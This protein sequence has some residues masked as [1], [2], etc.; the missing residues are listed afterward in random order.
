MPKLD[1]IAIQVSNIEASIT[2]YTEKIGLKLL[3]QKI[4][5]LHGEAFAFLELEGGNLELLQHLGEDAEASEFVAPKI[6][7]PYC[8]HFALATDD[9]NETVAKLKRNNVPIVAGPL[10][11]PDTV[12]WMY[13]SDPDNNIVEYIQYLSN[14]LNE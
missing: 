4:D 1:H 6:R 12:R 3:Y 8:P 14:F 9:L 7:K 13:L 5:K 11:I 10:E 2:F